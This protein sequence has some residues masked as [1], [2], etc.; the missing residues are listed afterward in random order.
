MHVAAAQGLGVHLFA[1]GRLHQR[2]PAEE[3]G[4]LVAHD[5]HLVAHGG[6][7]GAAGGARSHDHGDLGNAVG[8]Q[9]RL[10]VEDAPEVAPVREYPVLQGQEC[11]AGIHQVNAGQVIFGG[12][13]LGAEVFPDRDGVIG[14]ALDRR[15][16]D[17]DGAGLSRHAADAGDYPAAGRPVVVEF[18][19]AEQA[20]LEERG[21]RVQQRFEPLPRQ[22]FAAR[23]VPVA[24]TLVAR[25]V[26]ALR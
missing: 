21:A 11:A 17:D 26:R 20:D 23:G 13:L 3:N 24:G 15:I 25:P 16:V 8:G 14:A 12:N 5:D 10:V 6:H 18:V 4:A 19:A 9:V 2:G 1:G 7:V 22:Q